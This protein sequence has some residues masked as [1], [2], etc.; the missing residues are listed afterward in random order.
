M[1][2]VDDIDDQWRSNVIEALPGWRRRRG[3]CATHRPRCCRRSRTAQRE[4]RSSMSANDRSGH[5]WERDEHVDETSIRF[6]DLF[7]NDEP[8]ENPGARTA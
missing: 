2:E 6:Y 8:G 1:D 3:Q 5:E 4:P 7:T